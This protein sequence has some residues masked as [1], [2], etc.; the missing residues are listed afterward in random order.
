M[1][2]AEAAL[3]AAD[4]PDK[5]KSSSKKRTGARK[6]QSSGREDDDA[7]GGN[8][9]A[10]AEAK[11]ATK[12]AAAARRRKK[13]ELEVDQREA[14]LL[15]ASLVRLTQDTLA[16][17][18]G[19]GVGGGGGG[20]LASLLELADRTFPPATM[21]PPALRPSFWIDLAGPFAPESLRTWATSDLP[22]GWE[23][24]LSSEMRALLEKWC[25]EPEVIEAELDTCILWGERQT[26]SQQTATANAAAVAAAADAAHPE[27]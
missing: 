27:L 13:L 11:K 2:T 24:K 12:K 9:G 5:V 14:G 16:A 6:R 8:A 25:A 21:L 17:K 20:A 1:Q 18:K 10:K 3:A 22:A 26:Q 19:V 23:I 15:F 7:A 4:S